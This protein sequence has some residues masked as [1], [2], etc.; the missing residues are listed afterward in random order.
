MNK[1]EFNLKIHLINE[2]I[3]RIINSVE[4]SIG[5]LSKYLKHIGCYPIVFF[6]FGLVFTIMGVI[7]YQK[8]ANF[9][10]ILYFGE[11]QKIKSMMNM[12][13]LFLALSSIALSIRFYL[14]EKKAN[15]LIGRVK[16]MT[17]SPYKKIRIQLQLASKN[18]LEE[19]SP[20]TTIML[21]LLIP[22]P[23]CV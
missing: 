16:N 11:S 14:K 15:F 2:I 20:L 6:L 18:L 4:K 1:K 7:L 3:Q 19:K 5:K 23:S 9:Y 13:C 8:T 21:S 22:Y 12:T 17:D 10:Y